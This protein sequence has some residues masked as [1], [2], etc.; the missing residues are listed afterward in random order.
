MLDTIRVS[1]VLLAIIAVALI[2]MAVRP[3]DVARVG[4]GSMIRSAAAQSEGDLEKRLPLEAICTLSYVEQAAAKALV[5]DLQLEVIS[6]LNETNTALANMQTPLIAIQ[7]LLSRAEK[8][9]KT[10]A[11]NTGSY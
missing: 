1:N 3:Y 8:E 4:T 10:I 9:L 5:G 7:Q 6:A 2:W 11:N